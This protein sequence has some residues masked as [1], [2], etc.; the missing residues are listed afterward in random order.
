MKHLIVCTFKAQR[1]GYR[2]AVCNDPVRALYWRDL[3]DM[4]WRK[5]GRLG[6]ML[7][8]MCRWTD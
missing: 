6:R 5:A 1:Y 2:A 4:Y 7:D 8:A 3:A